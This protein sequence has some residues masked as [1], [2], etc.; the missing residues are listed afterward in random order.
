EDRDGAILAYRRAVQLVQSIRHDMA[1]RYGNPSSHSSFRAVSGPIYTQLADLILQRA[2]SDEDQASLR[3]A[4]DLHRASSDDDQ[5]NLREAR[6]VIESLRSAELEDYFQD[7]CVNLLKSKI[8]SIEQISATS[9]VVYV[10]PLPDRTELLVS[11]KAGIKRIKSP[12][13]DETLA[14]VV[15]D[16]RDNLEKRTT[17]EDLAQSEN[18]KD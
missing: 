11:L 13:A 15:H 5:A 2:S 8:T 17:S 6:D 14:A 1:L 16:F 9:A 18:L 12:V 10:I 4:R 7:Q 3:E